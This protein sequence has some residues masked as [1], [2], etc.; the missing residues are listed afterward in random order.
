M[1]EFK[2]L[3][4][5]DIEAR[6]QQVTEKGC[7]LLLYKDARCDMRM[8]D[9][10]VGNENWDCEYQSIDG[11]LFCTVGILCQTSSGNMA[12]VYKQDVGTKSNMEPEKGE[13]S[14]AFK[15][16]CFKWGIGR[17]LYTAPFIWVDKGQ[18]QK[19]YQD[20]RTGRWVCRDS[21]DVE[22]VEVKDGRI[23]DLA[24]VNGHGMYV[25]EMRRKP[26]KM[27]GGGTKTSEPKTAPQKASGGRYDKI[28]KLKAEAM[29]LG[30]REEGIESWIAA[31]FKGKAKKDM[32]DADIKAT[33]EYLQ[34]LIRDQKELQGNG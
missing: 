2:P 25:Y 32:S 16:A 31:T 19:H 6:V 34:T 28:R 11:R 21:F 4:P 29:A 12:W 3:E 15:R 7:S 33:E 8:L 5:E 14:D 23:T 17:E 20:Q 26:Q 18:L 1:I 13:A 10:T 30:V 24:I 9:E 22:R 27:V